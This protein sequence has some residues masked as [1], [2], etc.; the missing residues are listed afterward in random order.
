MTWYVNW[1]Q[2]LVTQLSQV[3]T[4][5]VQQDRCLQAVVKPSSRR[6]LYA[7]GS[8]TVTLLSEKDSRQ[9]DIVPNMN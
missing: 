1:Q 8:P 3:S 9:I 4:L 6:I 5:A 7:P 2:Q